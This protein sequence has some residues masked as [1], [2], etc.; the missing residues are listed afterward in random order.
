VPITLHTADLPDPPPKERYADS[1]RYGF[2]LDWPK[3]HP[4][5]KDSIAEIRNSLDYIELNL[6]P[7]DISMDEP[8]ATSVRMTQGGGKFIESRGNVIKNCTIGGTTGFLPSASDSTRLSGATVKRY[9][10]GL[11]NLS[12]EAENARANRSGFRAFYELRQLFREFGHARKQGVDVMMHYMDFKG[13]DFWLIEPGKFGMRRN[14]RKPYLYDY[15]ISFQCIEPSDSFSYTDNDQSVANNTIGTQSWAS[16]NGLASITKQQPYLA[17][18]K[19]MSSRRTDGLGYL[20]LLAGTVQRKFQG[21][22]NAIGN[23]VQFFDDVHSTLDAV[24]LDTPL[25]LLKQLDS[26]ITGAWDVAEKFSSDSVKAEIND[27]L[28]EQALLTKHMTAY[29]LRLAP[30]GQFVG[31]SVANF[32][33]SRGTLGSASDLLKESSPSAGINPFVGI[34]GL[35]DVIDTTSLTGSNTYRAEVIQTDET[36]YDVAERLLGNVQRFIELVFLN[37][38]NYPYIVPDPANKLPNTLAWGEY[39][40]V[41]SNDTADASA[42][43]SLGSTM[44]IPSF[45]GSVSATGTSSEVIDADKDEPWAVNQWTGYTVTLLTGGGIVDATRLVVSNDADTLVI[46]RPWTVSPAVDDTYKLMLDPFTLRKPSLPDELTFGRDILL[47]FN[48]KIG[49]NNPV[50]AEWVLNSR[51]DLATVSGM[52]NFIQAMS[53]LLYTERGRHPFHKTYGIAPSIGRPLDPGTGLLYSFF[54]RQA[55]LRDSRVASATKVQIEFEGG[56]FRFQAEVTPVK[57]ST[58]NLIKVAI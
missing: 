8:Y 14:S 35:E 54:A 28:L 13:D 52:E 53:L 55:L 22:L 38:L 15:N 41:P 1:Y 11:V 30:A 6:N 56:V 57:T 37:G 46:N 3:D 17:A 9:D 7:Q 19:R 12:A 31:N 47:K 21:V 51:G 50:T 4:R 36:I 33:Q 32:G 58:A 27:F 18:V 29:M 34:T 48:R 10:G 23:V 5:H 2:Y 26:A 16:L 20:K 39:I 24:L 45:S 49:S 42:S 40:K 44:T 25:N 43:V